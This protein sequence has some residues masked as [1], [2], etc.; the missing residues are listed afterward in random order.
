MRFKKDLLRIFA[1]STLYD[2]VLVSSYISGITRDVLQTGFLVALLVNVRRIVRIL[3]DMPVA[4]LC[5][6]I[7]LSRVFKLG[8]C[9]RIVFLLCI[10]SH[11]SH[12][13]F[14]GFILES[15]STSA[16]R[17]KVNVYQYNFLERYGKQD[18]YPKINNY[19]TSF[20]YFVSFVFGLL[21]TFVTTRWGLDICFYISI[22]LIMLSVF[23]I[24]EDTETVLEKKQ[25]KP[26][27]FASLKRIDPKL[28]PLIG[29]LAITTLGWQLCAIT[30]FLA[31]NTQTDKH[32]S[33]WVYT[34]C[35]LAMFI[36]SLLGG[37]ILTI[38]LTLKHY[39][40]TY[41]LVVLS[42]LIA[43]LSFRSK[44]LVYFI[45]PY[46][47]YFTT[48][49]SIL[50]TRVLKASGENRNFTL[51]VITTLNSVLSILLVTFYHIIGPILNYYNAYS[52]VWLTISIISIVCLYKLKNDANT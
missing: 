10:L 7:G 40:F 43:T 2:V 50:K 1:F 32:F 35:N 5:E 29:F 11:N 46:L 9:L 17:G 39:C 20:L 42:I 36:G 16:F 4:L 37:A 25:S 27:F 45:T 30:Q 49:E 28:F 51:S 22:G 8:A 33:A 34:Y 6:K 19:Y 13:I 48:F 21:A 47:L 3:F 31:I 18:L 38:R 44:N 41:A 15:I 26:S 12:L 14:I 52:F 23:F 24:V